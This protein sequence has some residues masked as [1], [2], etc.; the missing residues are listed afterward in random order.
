MPCRAVLLSGHHAEVARLAPGRGRKDHPR[1]P[2]RSLGAT[3]GN[4][5]GTGAGAAA[6]ACRPLTAENEKDN[7]MNMLQQFEAEQLTRLST[8]RA[9]PEFGPGD[10]CG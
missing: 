5:R 2:A 3:H 4:H 8:A 10:T 9:V 6:S 7:D 1:A